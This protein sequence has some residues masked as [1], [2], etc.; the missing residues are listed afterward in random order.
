MMNKAGWHFILFLAIALTFLF[1]SIYSIEAQTPEWSSLIPENFIERVILKAYGREFIYYGFDASTPLVF[2]VKGPTQ[3]RVLSR[4][5]FTSRMSGEQ[6]YK[7]TVLENGVEKKEILHRTTLSRKASY[8]EGTNLKLGK[9]M[10]LDFLVDDTSH[11]TFEVRFSSATGKRIEARLYKLKDTIE[12]A[13]HKFVESVTAFLT[14]SRERIYYLLNREHPL[15]VRVNGPTLLHVQT[16]LDYTPGMVG[17]QMYALKV[18]EDENI[19]KTFHIESVRSSTV[20]YKDRPEV[21]PGALNTLQIEV[22]AGLHLYEFRIS[23]S[24]FTGVALR[25]LVP[26]KDLW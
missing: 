2:Q 20:I 13:P 11:H 7:L 5:R 10:N 24:Q 3:V 4:L 12:L 16:R 15:Q 9:A 18:F 22:P 23:N 8:V 14:E 17:K 26:S 21:I 6:S 19:L 25:F 1:D